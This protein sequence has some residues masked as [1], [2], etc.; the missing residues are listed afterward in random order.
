MANAILCSP[1]LSD[2]AILT[3]SGW[4]GGSL[5]LSNLQGF[6]PR[7][8]ARSSTTT[9]HG[10]LDFGAAKA[11]RVLSLLYGNF[12]STDTIR[13]RGATS[14]AN[15]TAAPGY[16]STALPCWPGGADLASWDRRH[17]RLYLAAAQTF[18]W[19]RFDLNVAS[20]PAGYA[21]ASRVYVSEGLQP[22]KNI[23]TNWSRTSREEAVRTTNQSGG[24]TP[25][26]L[27]QHDAIE[28]VWKHLTEAEAFGGYA[29]LRRQR[30]ASGDVL[31]LVD[32]EQAT[33]PMDFM[34]YG[35]LQAESP[36]QHAYY[37]AGGQRYSVALRVEEP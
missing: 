33:Y 35:L 12:V 30:G 22:A 15:L 5:A 7:R 34:L 37:A 21:E 28:A 19:W 18:R 14:E 2:A 32:P 17:T 1:A 16:D 27:P 29:E 25:R 26:E 11:M 4:L 13:W 9:P 3:G 31:F 8:Y 24:I 36:M 23:A 20:N 10:V 6:D